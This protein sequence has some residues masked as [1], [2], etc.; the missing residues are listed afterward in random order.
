MR[1]LVKLLLALV[2]LAVLAAGG[3][4]L[5]LTTAYPAVPAP[6][7]VT[8]PT[9]SEALARGRYLAHHVALCI[10]CHAERDFSRFAGPIKP[11]TLGR[12]GE[13]FSRETDGVPGTI[14]SPNITPAGL[15]GYSD[16]ELLHAVTTGVAL[17]GR[18]LFPLMPYPNYGQLDRDD[19]LAMLAYVRTLDRIEHEVPARTLEFPVNLIVNTI[20]RAASFTTRPSPTDRVAYGKYLA[21]AA[22]CA[23][24]HTPM[25]DRGQRLPGMEFAGGMP[26]RL[27]A[28]GHRVNSANITPEA[29]TGIGQWSEEQFVNK[30]KAFETPDDRVLSADEQ[31]Q[32]TV[33]PWLQYAGMT[34]EDLGAIYAYL[35]TLKP[36][37]NR[38]VTFPDARA[39]SQ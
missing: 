9:S 35:R 7:A 25:D 13:R 38:V 23:E 22:S 31:R 30:F 12:G 5:Y 10:D 3:G 14:Y 37:V 18:A 1:I 19:V 20:P 29:D 2:A 34:R 4:Y 36:V 24:C 6:E 21:T 11:G 17:D 39:G 28:P 33:M 8:L 32:N 16:G 27:P 26:F 15:S